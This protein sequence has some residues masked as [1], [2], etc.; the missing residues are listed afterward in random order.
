MNRCYTCHT[1]DFADGRF[2]DIS[3]PAGTYPD[4]Q[5]L[6]CLSCAVKYT[7]NGTATYEIIPTAE[8]IETLHDWEVA[9]IGTN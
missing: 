4:N 5:N 6:H 3:S 1:D 8:Q 7:E 2:A 9:G